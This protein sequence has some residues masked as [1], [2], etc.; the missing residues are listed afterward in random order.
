MPEPYW[1]HFKLRPIPRAFLSDS[2][3]R[4]GTKV[5]HAAGR[6]AD[7]GEGGNVDACGVLPVSAGFPARAAAEG[8]IVTTLKSAGPGPPAGFWLG[9][10]VEA[11][12]GRGRAIG[13]EA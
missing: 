11:A 12:A 9:L 8:P 13:L 10:S 1:A 6:C 2:P 7:H 4:K 3:M 5:G